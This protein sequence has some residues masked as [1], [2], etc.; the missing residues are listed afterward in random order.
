LHQTKERASASNH[1]KAKFPLSC[2]FRY[3]AWVDADL[4][5][6]AY[7]PAFSAAVR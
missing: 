1:T 6:W 5:C 2:P 4:R 3:F 7:G